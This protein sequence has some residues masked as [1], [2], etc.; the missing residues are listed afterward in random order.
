ME[1]VGFRM[2]ASPQKQ[3][4]ILESDL[5]GIL[6]ISKGYIG[7]LG[8]KV[9]LHVSVQCVPLANFPLLCRIVGGIVKFNSVQQ[10]QYSGTACSP[11]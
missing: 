7:N 9:Q 11:V 1:V 3:G 5:S 10:H 8:N 6:K 4:R 2:G